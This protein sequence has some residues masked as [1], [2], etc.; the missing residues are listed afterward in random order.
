MKPFLTYTQQIN[1]LIY[2]KH[3]IIS[4]IKKAQ[5]KLRD[6]GYFTLIGGYKTL[7]LDPMT[8]VYREDTHFEDIY[9][10]YEFDNRLHELFFRH[11]CQIEKKMRNLIS[12]A[13]CEVYGER[14]S[15][16]LST[17]N[18][19]YSRKNQRGINKLV[20]MMSQL[21]NSN[22]DYDFLI[23][24]RRVY[25]NVPL[26]VLVNAMTFGQISKMYAFLPASIRSKISHN[27]V[28]VSERELE[29]YLKVLVLYRN[30][31]A[32][33]ERLFSHKVYSEIPNTKLHLKLNIPQ[34]GT[35]Y[36]MGKKDLFCIVIAFRYLLSKDDFK[37]FKKELIRSIDKC[38]S[39]SHCI[40]ELKLLNAMGFPA[41]WKEI[42]KYRI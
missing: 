5:E 8:R 13:F 34:T 21:A 39:Q 24:Q 22:T 31:C 41:N 35:Q 1:K 38:L 9:N 18:Y 14:Q 4:D 33:N 12:Y 28:H 11:L 25:Q 6:V 36:L 23:Y 30:V 15:A 10:L 16:Y 27:Y 7:F 42:T 20:K 32:H 2:E 19:N 3:L 29:Q 17:S 26:W 37:E 40:S